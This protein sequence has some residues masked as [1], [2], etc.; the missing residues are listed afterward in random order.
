[1]FCPYC[2]EPLNMS[3]VDDIKGKCVKC[4]AEF[5]ITRIQP[6]PQKVRATFEIEITSSPADGFTIEDDLKLVLGH[7]SIPLHKI[8]RI[9]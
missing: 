3:D 8:R 2:R 6:K 9:S 1:M 7:F 5:S 4:N